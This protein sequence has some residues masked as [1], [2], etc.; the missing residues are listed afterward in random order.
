MLGDYFSHHL[1]VG[2]ARLYLPPVPDHARVGHDLLNLRWA[3]LG[4]RPVVTEPMVDSF[5]PFLDGRGFEA[6]IEGHI[7]QDGV[8]AWIVEIARFA[9][10][11]RVKCRANLPFWTVRRTVLDER[12]LQLVEEFSV[13]VPHIPGFL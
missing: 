11:V 12:S 2:N 5:V 3:I 8:V 4:D 13:W 1:G 6:G 7:D 9:V 10:L